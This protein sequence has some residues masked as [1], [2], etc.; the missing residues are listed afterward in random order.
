[1]ISLSFA[2]VTLCVPQYL[3]VLVYD[4]VDVRSFQIAQKVLGIGSGH[5]ISE[6]LADYMSQGGTLG[7]LLD[8][9]VPLSLL[10][11]FWSGPENFN[12]AY[13]NYLVQPLFKT[14]IFWQI[15]MILGA[16]PFLGMIAEG[17]FQNRQRLNATRLRAQKLEILLEKGRNVQQEDRQEV[18]DQ[19]NRLQSMA[20]TISDMA[21][22]ISATLQEESIYKLVLKKT[23]E[24]LG[25]RRTALF[26]PD[27]LGEELHLV[28]YIGYNP[29]QIRS[30]RLKIS[31]D[32]GIL[33]WVAKHRLF[34]SMEDVVGDYH[35]AELLKT[36]KLETI[37][38]QPVVHSGNLLFVICVG[39]TEKRLPRRHA[40]RLMTLLANFVSIGI[41]NARLLE[42]THQLAI[43]DGLTGVYNHRYFQ[44]HLDAAL[45][46]SRIKG[47][48]VS[49]I[50][51]DLDHFKELNDSY[52][53]QMGDEVL[54]Q[55]AQVLKEDVGPEGFVARYGGEEFV[56]V[57]QGMKLVE[58]R[59]VAQKMQQHIEK[60]PFG[61][62]QEK[63]RA[64]IS[65]GVAWH[66]P[67]QDEWIKKDELIKHSDDA[68][69]RAKRN[70][71][72]Q[73]CVWEDEASQG[74]QARKA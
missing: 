74:S 42:Q 24:L 30:V 69:Y 15:M 44:E 50:L 49:C 13:A 66:H 45:H 65:L 33:G 54:R 62:K 14:G 29:N 19:I 57:Q 35:K 52:G 46:D 12:L 36:N 67:T 56:A 41:Q 51:I 68:L 47:E 7:D 25:A 39:K 28:D 21:R 63:I 6:A 70:G 37:Y 64:T 23:G 34:L 71:R 20:I 55:V 27:S 40:A 31:E 4:R 38:A 3:Y 22:E 60:L 53:H 61:N 32:S 2:A 26:A 9:H 58:V 1:V 48:P 11:R 73:V 8:Q 43:Q 72:N 10:H 18:T 5:S 59:S 16:I 17:G